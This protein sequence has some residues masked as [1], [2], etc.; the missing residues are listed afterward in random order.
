MVSLFYFV[1]IHFKYIFFME[2][3]II[4][5]PLF[6]VFYNG[7]IYQINEYTVKNLQLL[8]SKKQINPDDFIFFHY[9]DKMETRVF[10]QEDGSF[11]ANLDL[12][13]R[14]GESISICSGLISERWK[15]RY[16][17]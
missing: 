5:T 3:F 12:T 13:N 2:D 6:S 10:L 4:K 7:E 15:G 1:L 11:P 16:K 9:D 14:Y 17:D 8:V